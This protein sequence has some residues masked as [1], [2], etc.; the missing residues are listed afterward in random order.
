MTNLKFFKLGQG[1]FKIL[2]L[3]G[4]HGNE[5]GPSPAL[6]EFV[7][8]FP[9]IKKYIRKAQYTVIPIVS[10]NAS[11]E[12]KRYLDTDVNRQFFMETQ[13]PINKELISFIKDSDL[14]IDFHE[15][16]NYHRLDPMS[17]GQTISCLT[18][19]MDNFVKQTV[20]KINS[21]I[22]ESLKFTFLNKLPNISGTL[23]EFC[24]NSNIPYILIEIVGQNNALPQSLREHLAHICLAA[25]TRV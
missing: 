10:I 17:L 11:K 21:Q 22:S 20:Q 19:G 1:S 8:C 15:A 4:V 16:Y 3:G 25:L 5:I 14:V 2:I 7:R 9:Y 13:N 18:P 12:N 24:F 6:M 23:D